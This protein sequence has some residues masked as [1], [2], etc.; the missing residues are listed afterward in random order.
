VSGA[1]QRAYRA[2]LGAGRATLPI[3]VDL[4]DYGRNAHRGGTIE[5]C[6]RDDRTA[7]VE[8]LERLVALL[9]A[10]HRQRYA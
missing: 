8:A 5:P 1:R 3:E 7:V 6:R 9:N 4:V 2:R 10:D